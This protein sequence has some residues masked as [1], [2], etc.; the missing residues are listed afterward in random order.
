MILI[1]GIAQTLLTLALFGPGQQPASDQASALRRLAATALLGAQE[2]RAGVQ[3]GHVVAKA[4]IEEARLFFA[5]ARRSA[6]LLSPDVSTS[7]V[8][9]LDEIADLVDATAS[10]DTIQARSEEHTSELQ[11]LRHLVC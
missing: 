9:A 8:R 1:G 7:A 3:N 6:G 10:P 11:S 4:E 2:Y 5:E